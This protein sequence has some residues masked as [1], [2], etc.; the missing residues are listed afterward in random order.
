[1]DLTREFIWTIADLTH[2]R[3]S[4]HFPRLIAHKLESSSIAVVDSVLV[5]LRCLLLTCALESGPQLTRLVICSFTTFTTDFIYFCLLLSSVS[6]DLGGNTFS[7][8]QFPL[9][10]FWPNNTYVASDVT[11]GFSLQRSSSEPLR[12]DSLFI[13]GYQGYSSFINRFRRTVTLLPP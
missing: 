8:V 12:S 5:I 1:M 2:N 11:M 13:I 6:V 10:S 3:C 9:L 7:R 4:T